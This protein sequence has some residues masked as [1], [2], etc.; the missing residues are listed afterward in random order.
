MSSFPYS[1]DFPVQN[2]V[3]VWAGEENIICKK[4]I[5]QN[6]KTR[7]CLTGILRELVAI[8][9]ATGNGTHE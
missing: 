7:V 9:P 8:L 6:R 3:G 5:S 2:F 4:T 1:Y